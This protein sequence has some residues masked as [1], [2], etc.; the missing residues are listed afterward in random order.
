MYVY[1]TNI[2]VRD[3]LL[4]HN[5]NPDWLS[6][7]EYWHAQLFWEQWVGRERVAVEC[8]DEPAAGDRDERVFRMNAVE[9]RAGGI[10]GLGHVGGGGLY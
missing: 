5:V 1:G 10:I 6:S 9:L 4:Y 2:A 8:V 7:G 3:N